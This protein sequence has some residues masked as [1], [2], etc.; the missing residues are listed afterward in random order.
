M[1]LM[2]LVAVMAAGLVLWGVLRFIATTPALLKDVDTCRG[3][4]AEARLRNCQGG[5]AATGIPV[6]PLNSFSS[7]A[8]LVAGW[9]VYRAFGNLPA[10]VLGASLTLNG[11]GSALYHGTKAM[12]AARLDHAGMYAVFGSL[13]IYS[14]A[15]PHPAAP[16]VMLAGAAVFAI[17]FAVVMPGD[18]NARTGM[19]LCLLSVRGFLLGRTLLSA[20]SLGI[21]A[22]AFTA[23]LLDRHTTVLSRFGHAIWH[24]FTA[25]AIGLMFGAV[26]TW[27]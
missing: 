16:Y 5:L 2:Y 10:V 20:L 17:G 21:F 11:V 13:A 8:Y 3:D 15:P 4:W 27:S 14:V 9:T 23:W 1:W 18:L 24:L 7:L 12:W 22:V 26:L 25:A 6:E 19:L